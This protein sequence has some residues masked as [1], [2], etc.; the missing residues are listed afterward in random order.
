[1]ARIGSF[2]R[3][4]HLAL[5]LV[6]AGFAVATPGPASAAP[7]PVALGGPAILPV[8]DPSAPTTQAST[9]PH[10]DY[11][12]GP[13]MA[14][15]KVAQVVYGAGT[16]LTETTRSSAP[17]VSSFLGSVVGSGYVTELSEY[18][19][20][21]TSILG[22]AGTQQHIGAGTFL[23]RFTIAPAPARNDA[24]I[25]DADVQAELTAQLAA[26]T[27]PA[28]SLDAGGRA[29]TVYSVFFRN[30]QRICAGASCS[31]QSPGF[32]AYHS[33]FRL[34]GTGP[35]VAYSVHP[36]LGGFEGRGC[37]PGTAFQITTAAVSHEL[38]EV[39]T[40]PYIG[41]VSVAA[42]PLS[43]WDLA[44]SAKGENA[45]ICA[46]GYDTLVL[47][48]VGYQ[49]QQTWS[50][51]ASACI[52][53]G[54]APHPGDF[55][56]QPRTLAVLAGGVV[57]ATVQSLGQAPGTYSV[58]GL[59]PGTTAALSPAPLPGGATAQLTIRAETTA[60]P[61]TY[62]LTVANDLGGAQSLVLAVES[63][64]GDVAS[65]L[66]ADTGI[67]RLVDTRSGAPVTPDSVLRVDPGTADA[68]AVVLDVVA[69]DVTAAG[70]VTVWP[71]DQPRP[72][73]SNLNTTPG[74]TVA[75]LV[76]VAVRPGGAVC[77]FHSAGHAHLVVDRVA[78]YRPAGGPTRSGRL[79]P[80]TP[81]RALDTRTAG[82][83]FAAGEERSLDLRGAGVPVDASAVVLTLT[84]VDAPADGW[85]AV[86]PSGPWPGTSNLNAT[87]GR[88]TA[89]QAIVPSARGTVVLRSL[90]G[91]HLVVDVAGFFTGTIDPEDSAG[92]FHPR[93]PTRALDTR[94]A[95][96]PRGLGGIVGLER[97]VPR[98][99]SAVVLNVTV[100]DPVAPG[101]ATVYPASTSPP[102]A[103]NLNFVAGDTVPGHVVVGVADAQ[104]GLRTNVATHMVVDVAG[105]YS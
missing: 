12:G 43:W 67:V 13:V 5:A 63:P 30:G 94:D 16:F 10:L 4:V 60:P 74:R 52:T 40:N 101:F 66:A 87:V 82:A 103:S 19:T 41:L 54:L 73:A 49:V 92:Q 11:Y 46:D 45:D 42:P 59:P 35:V 26:G 77:L 24:S 15:A 78:V 29:S 7:P 72:V 84:A 64:T 91:G 95:G 27:L 32:C 55:Q 44:N 96:A 2:A 38:A 93:T 1:M 104:V 100:T 97:V 22:A 105:W 81:T 79:L 65:V 50:N 18:D 3:R 90:A 8:R 17:S 83:P 48:G 14:N 31:L 68:T 36:D 56:L 98:A 75:N 61:G 21:V 9:T 53:M 62:P 99:S 39:I 71:C 80:I 37:G 25:T 6:V 34:N 57:R 86:W 33:T 69:T 76:T 28:P 102:L 85:W 58:T 70:F 89:N 88:V 47:D 51:A 23:G 20:T